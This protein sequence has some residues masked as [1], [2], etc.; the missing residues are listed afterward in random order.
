[1]VIAGSASAT[2]IQCQEYLRNEGYVVGPKITGACANDT[3]IGYSAC[4]SEL[5]LAGVKASYAV[6][7]CNL[8]QE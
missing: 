2:P 7:A 6:T 1:L 5:V 8:A 3:A 4:Y